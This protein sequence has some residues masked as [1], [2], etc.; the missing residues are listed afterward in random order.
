MLEIDVR[1]SIDQIDVFLDGRPQ[2]WAE[3]KRPGGVAVTIDRTSDGGDVVEVVGKNGGKIVAARRF[4][5]GRSP[6]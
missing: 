6:E 4:D 2:G 1:G 3:I 5:L